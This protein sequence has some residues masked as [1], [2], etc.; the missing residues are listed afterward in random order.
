MIKILAFLVLIY[1]VWRAVVNGI[2]SSNVD[3]QYGNFPPSGTPNYMGR[4]WGWIVIGFVAA[5]SSGF[6]SGGTGECV[7]RWC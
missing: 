3:K 5:M 7:G 1:A 2:E 4:M 6:F